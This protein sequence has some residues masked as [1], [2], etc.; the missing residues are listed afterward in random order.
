MIK[1]MERLTV[2]MESQVDRDQV[3]IDDVHFQ[4]SDSRN[5]LTIWVTRKEEGTGGVWLSY[6]EIQNLL[7][8]KE[9]MIERGEF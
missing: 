7:Q 1:T 2:K 4:K 8:L 3:Y 5:E 9:K 6:K